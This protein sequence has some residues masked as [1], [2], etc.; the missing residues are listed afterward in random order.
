M[1]QMQ[2]LQRINELQMGLVN[3]QID[4]ERLNKLKI[5]IIQKCSYIKHVE[6]TGPE[7]NIN[8]VEDYYK[9]A[10]L[11]KTYSH[12]Q[13]YFDSA[14]FTE[15]Y[16]Q[17]YDNYNFP[18]LVTI[19][20]GILN[21]D[22]DALTELSDYDCNK[23]EILKYDLIT[24]EN[25]LKKKMDEVLTTPEAFQS[26]EG[27]ALLEEINQFIEEKRMNEGQVSPIKYKDQVVD[28][29]KKVGPIT[30]IVDIDTVNTLK[31]FL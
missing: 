14:D 2:V 19:I 13:E 7:I 15:Y 5:E 18:Y 6:T 1:K 11:Q 21:G 29:I 28:C 4:D 9:Y 27:K 26:A 22:K 12:C 17:E 24:K 10:N 30:N 25:A 23:E 3:Y 31:K 8:S 20:K 16:H